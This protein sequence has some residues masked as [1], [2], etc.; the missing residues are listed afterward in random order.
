MPEIQQS[1]NYKRTLQIGRETEDK[2]STPHFMEWVKEIPDPKPE[3][4]KYRTKTSSKSGKVSHYRLY[5][6][7]SGQLV[8]LVRETKTIFE[9]PEEFLFATIQDENG[10]I[11]I[12][13][14][15]FGSY[16]CDLMKRLLDYNFDPMLNVALSPY[17]ID[18]QNGKG[19]N[20]GIAIINGTDTQLAGNKN[21]YGTKFAAPHLA[22]MPDLVR[23]VSKGKE[24]YDNTEQILWL[25]SEIERR[26]VPKLFGDAP[27]PVP[28]PDNDPRF[29]T[30]EEPQNFENNAPDGD[31]LP[32]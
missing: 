16:A 12:E 1:N 3:K 23:S 7:W 30:V 13:M 18:K 17:A 27:Q 9:T 6:G 2:T 10:E 26:V 22:E 28:Q 20:V 25:W 8:S 5:R 32:F 4:S 14:P 21:A 19:Q 31:D 15:L 29:P 11:V 24:T